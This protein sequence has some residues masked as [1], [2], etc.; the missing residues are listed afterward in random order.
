MSGL[1]DD[2]EQDWGQP[3]LIPRRE[4]NPQITGQEK[5]SRIGP[6]SSKELHEYGHTLSLIA[7]GGV[8][9]VRGLSGLLFR[10]IGSETTEFLCGDTFQ[11]KS[12]YD[13]VNELRVQWAELWNYRQTKVNRYTY[14]IRLRFPLDADPFALSVATQNFSAELTGGDFGGPYRFV[15]VNHFEAEQTVSDLIINRVPIS[16]RT[17]HISHHSITPDQ[18]RRLLLV[19]LHE[20]AAIGSKVDW[21]DDNDPEKTETKTGTTR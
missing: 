15:L 7:R 20:A 19:N 21:Y 5:L 8:K 4:Q 11:T 14:H 1:F 13:A 16:G 6:T 12:G 18:L 3:T 17:L 2:Y 9:S 10:I